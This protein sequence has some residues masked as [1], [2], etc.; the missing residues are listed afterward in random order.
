MGLPGWLILMG[1]LTAI[2]PISIDMYL[3][4]F[5]EIARGLSTTSNEVERTLAAYLIGM[6]SAQLIYGPWQIALAVNLRYM[7]RSCSTSSPRRPVPLPRVSN[8]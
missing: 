1:A 6:A 7:A 4:A 2:G 8:F 5:P 3:P